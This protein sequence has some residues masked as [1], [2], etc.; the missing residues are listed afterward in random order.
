MMRSAWRRIITVLYYR[1]IF[2]AIGAKSILYKD[3]IVI[4]SEFIKIG[5]GVTIR[6]GSRLE[7]VLHNQ[8][9][10][11]RLE[12]GNNVNIEQNVHIVCHDRVLIGDDVSIAPMCAIVDTKHPYQVCE[13][14]KKIGSA[15]DPER[16]AVIIGANSFLGVGATIL[17]G[18]T[19]G[20]Q[21]VIGAGS[22]VTRDIPPGSVV[23][24][25]PAKVIGSVF[26][27]RVKQTDVSEKS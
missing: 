27:K 20:E 11:P 26:S 12:I 6:G 1:R 25:S 19:I 18:V 21:C 3:I 7:V 17:P 9:W 16:S 14:G 4:N 10:L 15:I 13:E 5:S 24:G 23:A 2:R 22:V 8:G